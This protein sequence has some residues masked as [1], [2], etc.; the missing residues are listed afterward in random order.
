MPGFDGTG[1]AGYGALTGGGRGYC[2]GVPVRPMRR[3]IPGGGARGFGFGY[4]ARL[5]GIPGWRSWDIPLS[6]KDELTGLSAQAEYLEE[7]LSAV[8]ERI[9]SLNQDKKQN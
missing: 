5:T 8:R 2:A 6:A 1:P 4:R 9:N 3:G 7:Q